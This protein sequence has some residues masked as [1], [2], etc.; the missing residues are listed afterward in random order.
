[1]FA[2][3]RMTKDVAEKLIAQNYPFAQNPAV[4]YA[5]V[6]KAAQLGETF[7]YDDLVFHNDKTGTSCRGHIVAR[8]YEYT[9]QVVDR[10]G[11][12]DKD[13]PAFPGIRSKAQY[14]TGAFVA[15]G[16]AYGDTPVIIGEVEL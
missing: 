3:E 11:N 16:M 4:L 6:T 2:L 13:Y 10:W 5:T 7:S 1:M 15:V 9:L 8:W 12:V 14:E